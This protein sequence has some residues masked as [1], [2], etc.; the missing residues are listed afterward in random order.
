MIIRWAAL[1]S[2]LSGCFGAAGLT[3][4]VAGSSPSAYVSEAGVPGAPHATLYAAS[5]VLLALSLA[6]LAG[7]ARRVC[8]LIGASLLL[9]APMAATSGAVRCSP[10][11]P[12]P[13]YDSPTV[14]DLVHAAA[15]IA[16]LSL[17]AL[18]IL[19]YCLLPPPHRWTG[20]LGVLIAYP[21]LLL[22]AGGIL[23]V[24]RSLFTGVTERAALVAVSAWVVLTAVRHVREVS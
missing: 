18:A 14:R 5:M 16:A 1:G 6:L 9:A 7:P 12:L 20:W 21:P 13:P 3:A 8:W 2:A 19:L 23:F 11:C 17:C 22:S 15:A 24:G 10:G 4:A